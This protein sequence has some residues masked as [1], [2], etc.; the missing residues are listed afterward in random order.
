MEV[1]PPSIV[2]FLKQ[3]QTVNK[4]TVLFW[5]KNVTIFRFLLVPNTNT[6]FMTDTYHRIYKFIDMTIITSEKIIFLRNTRIFT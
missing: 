5:N 1:L 2:T 4:K 6:L 3:S